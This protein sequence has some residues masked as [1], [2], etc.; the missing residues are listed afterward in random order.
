MGWGELLKCEQ[1]ATTALLK[2]MYVGRSLL[3]FAI[4]VKPLSYRPTRDLQYCSFEV[5]ALEFVCIV[6]HPA[7]TCAWKCRS[8]IASKK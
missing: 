5:S 2:Y 4:A 1:K 8:E 6:T 3:L 7:Y